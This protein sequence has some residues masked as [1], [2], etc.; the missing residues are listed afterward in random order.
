MQTRRRRRSSHNSCKKW[1]APS[2]HSC[3][4]IP[5]I[6]ESQIFLSLKNGSILCLSQKNL[7]WVHWEA[8]L[9]LVLVPEDLILGSLE[10]MAASR[11][12]PR[13]SCFGFI[14]KHGCISCLSQ[15]ILF[16]VHW[17]AWLHLLF[18]PEHLVLVNWKAWLQLV[19]VPEHHVLGSLESMAPSSV[20]PRTSCF[21]FTGKH[22]SIFC[23]S[24]N[25]LFWVHWKAWSSSSSCLLLLGTEDFSATHKPPNVFFVAL[26]LF[27]VDVYLYSVRVT[28]RK[29]LKESKR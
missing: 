11:V 28:G 18:V 4:S 5:S 29:Q 25:I 9:H 1:T 24:Q 21:G 23:L 12:C 7:F 14:G 3:I 20:C 2:W 27:S 6:Q 26:S 17:K 19:F 8:W 22:G 13:T 16:W 10:S 15:N